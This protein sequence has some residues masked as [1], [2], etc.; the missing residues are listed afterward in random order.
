MQ[1]KLSPFSLDILQVLKGA[2]EKYAFK[3]F[4]WIY[5]ANIYLL[6]VK[7]RNTRK[8]YEIYPN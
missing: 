6:K 1:E 7:N 2:M 3:T 5:P 4:S 8:S